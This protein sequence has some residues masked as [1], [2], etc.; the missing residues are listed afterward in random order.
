MKKNM[1]IILPEFNIITQ[2]QR[3]K[4]V[5]KLIKRNLKIHK[6]H[7]LQMVT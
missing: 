1:A 7:L 2:F 3:R 5:D 4:N 6:T